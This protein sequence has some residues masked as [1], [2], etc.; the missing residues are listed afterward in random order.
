MKRTGQLMMYSF[1]KPVSLYTA[2]EPDWS[3]LKTPL[4]FLLLPALYTLLKRYLP[5]QLH[6]KSAIIGPGN[7]KNARI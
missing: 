1:K 7:I 3:A 5:H 2:Y 4:I 6:L